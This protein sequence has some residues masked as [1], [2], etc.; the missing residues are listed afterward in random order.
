MKHLTILVDMDDTVENLLAA[1]VSYLNHTYGTDVDPNSVDDWDI[2]KFF[3]TLTKSQVY[4][5]LFI[6]AFWYCVKPKDGASDALQRLIA[7]GHKVF[8]VTSSTHETLSTKMTA[9]LF[10]YFPFLTWNDV[11]ITSRK[12]LIRGDV[13]VDDGIHNL[14]GGEYAKILFDAP[15]NR[16]YNAEANDM[17]R[18]HNWE[19]A[20]AV[21]CGLAQ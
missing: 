12:Q 5:P 9:V 21:I 7:D 15:H 11:I 2:S 17:V 14:E 16:H 13:L 19:E 3:P 10:K 4:G 1:W 18:V 8:I 6:D 20:Y